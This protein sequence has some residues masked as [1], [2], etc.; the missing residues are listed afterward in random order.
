M[1]IL[2]VN[3][4]VLFLDFVVPN[5]SQLNE[6]RRLLNKGCTQKSSLIEVSPDATNVHFAGVLK[7]DK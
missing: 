7:Y 2:V 6:S 4:L 1:S 5:I 3:L